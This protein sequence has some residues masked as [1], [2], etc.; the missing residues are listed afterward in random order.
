LRQT[1]PPTLHAQWGNDMR[2]D[3]RASLLALEERLAD[4]FIQEA[5][6]DEWDEDRGERYKQ[7]RSAAETASLLVRTQSL[8]ALV[9]P[10]NGE[11]DPHEEKEASSLIYRAEQRATRAVEQALAKA[12]RVRL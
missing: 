8:M 7:K 3:Q 11:V 5:D 4:L 6:P 1:A 9:P 10:P 2:P 12:K